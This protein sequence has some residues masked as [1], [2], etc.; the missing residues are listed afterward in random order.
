MRISSPPFKYPCY[1]GTDVP[2]C[3]QLVA[4]NHTVEEIRD[5]I[6]A[7]SL[8]YLDAG[9]LNE[10]IGGDMGYCH[11]CFSGEYPME[12]PKGDIRGEYEK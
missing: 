5:M 1:F 4:Y 7:D 6:G 11:A 3:D 9:R 10:L 12:T 8:G 2:S